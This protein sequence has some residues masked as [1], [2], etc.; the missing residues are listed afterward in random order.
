[1]SNSFIRLQHALPHH[2]VSRLAGKFAKSE[3]PWIKDRLIR[4]FIAAYDVDM[5]EAARP[6]ETYAS[7]NDFFTR[8]LKPG[9]RPFADADTHVLSP[10]DGAISQI[11]RIEKGRVFQAKGRE[12]TAT[13]LLGGDPAL[14]EHYNGGSF[15]TIYLSPKDYHRV[16]MPAA[17][18]LLG[19]IY[20][21]GDLFS[22]N[23][24]TAENVDDLFARNERLACMFDGPHGSFA[25]VMVGAMIVAGIETVWGGREHAHAPRVRSATFAEG[26]HRFA[27]GDEMGRFFLGSTVVLL[28]E[29]GRVEWDAAL[30][31]GDSVKMGEALGRWVQ[32]KAGA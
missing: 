16:H 7:F 4:R 2:A 10:A 25:S 26:E 20:V 31:A 15:A 23:Q 32:P 6:V 17:G 30:S 14:A 19:T 21:P 28:F 12:F 9:A 18:E 3:K 13:Q 8:E 5:S 24:V 11:G 29:P 27:A 1:M 22:V